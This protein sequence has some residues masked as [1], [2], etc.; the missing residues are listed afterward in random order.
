MSPIADPSPGEITS[1][2]AALRDRARRRA[3][4]AIEALALARRERERLA[5]NRNRVQ[6]MLREYGAR[7]QR[8][9]AGAHAISEAVNHREFLGH[10]R[11]LDVRVSRQLAQADRQLD[12]LRAGVVAAEQA[13]A[14]LAKLLE[15]EA[16]LREAH[17]ARR[18]QRQLDDWAV[19]QAGLRAATLAAEDDAA[20]RRE[21]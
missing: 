14:K 21:A 13:V 9:Q 17:A 16:Q 10:L 2:W 19:M 18:E 6:T 8:L 15:R 5:H 12:E 4:R 3:D 20:L 7:L 11:R 1:P